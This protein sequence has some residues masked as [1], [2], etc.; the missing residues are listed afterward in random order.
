MISIRIEGLEA[1]QRQLKALPKEIEKAIPQALNDTA[2]HVRSKASTDIRQRWAIKKRDLDPYFRITR[3]TASKPVA[4]VEMKSASIPLI[5][6]GAKKIRQGVSVA[7]V[8]GKRTVLKGAFIAQMQSGHTG[9]FRRR[10][11]S[12]KQGKR[13]SSLPV[14]EVKTGTWKGTTY[15]PALPIGERFTISPTSMWKQVLAET[16]RDAEAFLVKRL[17]ARIE[18]AISRRK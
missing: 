9:V 7:I 5:A 6:F 15:R 11:G 10:F 18:L 4:N 3:A 12:R 17:R 16:K 13:Y 14:R 8:K 1:L 2:N